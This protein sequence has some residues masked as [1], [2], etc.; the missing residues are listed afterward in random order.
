MVSDVFEIPKS[1]N[2]KNKIPEFW[3][4]WWW[5][6][7]G[8]VQLEEIAITRCFLIQ[9]LRFWGFWKFGSVSYRLRPLF[10]THSLIYSSFSTPFRFL[11]AP[12]CIYLII[13][14]LCLLSFRN[15]IIRGW[16]K[17]HQH[18]SPHPKNMKPARLIGGHGDP[19]GPIGTHGDPSRLIGVHG[20]H[21]Y[22]LGP[23]AV[24][25]THL[26]LPANREV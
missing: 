1:E 21:P 11:S 8:P 18:F 4:N 24:S 2:K 26:T 23:V 15:T 6:S 7:S 19:P 25:Y 9:Y 5:T 20:T 17:T 3:W 12:I 22:S 13:F 16:W 14:W 10:H